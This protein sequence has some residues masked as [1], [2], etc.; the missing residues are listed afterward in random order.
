MGRQSEH[1]SEKPTV[2][3]RF[4]LGGNRSWLGWCALLVAVAFPI[5]GA[6]AGYEIE[7]PESHDDLD[8]FAGIPAVIGT[9]IGFIAGVSSV[10]WSQA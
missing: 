10:P 2:L 9:L 8:P 1:P 7:K 5:V 3:G 4:R 6:V